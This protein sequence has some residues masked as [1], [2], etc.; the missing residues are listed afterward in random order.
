MEKPASD[1]TK[2]PQ[3]TSDEALQRYAVMDKAI[4]N[5]DF[6]ID[7][8]ESA[9]GMYMVGFHFGW[10]VLYLVHTKKTIRKYE[11]LLNIKVAE[12][13]PEYG[14]DADRTNAYKVIQA[15]NSFWKL[16]S[17]DEKPTLKV[18]KRLVN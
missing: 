6:Q 1:S 7:E 16:V 8:L 12:T 10:R 5:G 18:D 17:G 2:T 4:R 13:F 15:A 14:R 11:T 9:L 3:A